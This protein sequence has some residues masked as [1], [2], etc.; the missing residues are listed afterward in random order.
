MSSKEDLRE[1]RKPSSKVCDIIQYQKFT[2][3]YEELHSLPT[4]IYAP[5]PRDDR[6]RYE[7]LMRSKVLKISEA[8]LVEHAAADPEEFIFSPYLVDCVGLIAS[9]DTGE[10]SKRVYVGHL[11]RSTAKESL[12]EFVKKHK[13]SLSNSEVCIITSVQSDVLLLTYNMLKES[14]FK[15]ISKSF[16]PLVR[17]INQIYVPSFMFKYAEKDP[18]TLVKLVER[19]VRNWSSRALIVSTATGG[20]FRLNP[21]QPSLD[22][23]ELLDLKGIKPETLF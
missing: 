19:D 14:G 16:G 23:K 11:E 3:P 20:L 17:E 2:Q 1:G 18:A 22:S 13:F 4:V 15:K 9:E 21:E 8:C 10:G 5:F 12:E 7:A 6:S